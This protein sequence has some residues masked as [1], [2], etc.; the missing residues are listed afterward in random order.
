VRGPGWQKKKKTSP[1][2]INPAQQ[3]KRN[4]KEYHSIWR[5]IVNC[6]G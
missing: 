1:G 6:C 4:E 5:A 2:I 3:S